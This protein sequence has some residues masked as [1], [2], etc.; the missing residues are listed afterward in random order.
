MGRYKTVI[1]FISGI[2]TL[3]HH[4]GCEE[5]EDSCNFFNESKSKKCLIN[6]CHELDFL[7]ALIF[8]TVIYT[9]KFIKW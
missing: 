7:G 1:G 4:Y 3:L 9:I 5:S 8:L 2:G 6:I